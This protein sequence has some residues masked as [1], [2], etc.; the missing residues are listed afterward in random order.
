MRGGRPQRRHDHFIETGRDAAELDVDDILSTDGALHRS[1]SNE[2]VLEDLANLRANGIVSF[3]VARG[4]GSCPFD[5]DEDTGQGCALLAGHFTPHCFLLGKSWSGEKGY[6]KQRQEHAFFH[7]EVYRVGRTTSQAQAGPLERGISGPVVQYPQG[8][9]IFRCPFREKALMRRFIPLALAASVSWS[10]V[11]AAQIPDW[12]TQ[13]LAAAQLPV[14]AAEA[15][16]EGVPNAEVRAVLDAL[17]GANVPAHEARQVIDEERSARREHGPVDNFGAFVQSKLQAGLR[18][19][20]LA[21]AIRAEHVARGRGKA[22]QAQR[23][24]GKSGAVRDT[25]S[26][27]GTKGASKAKRPAS[28]AKRP[29]ANGRTNRP[30]G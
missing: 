3:A 1:A 10:S 18:G 22:G 30:Q 21:A 8:V 6:A 17:R 4:A 12:V 25:M 23:D 9:S 13:I 27:R 29:D 20:D 19:R 11:A 5:T 24:K 2:P 28:D 14:S 7:S 15:R 26:A 16:R